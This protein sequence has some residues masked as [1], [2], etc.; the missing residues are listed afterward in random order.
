MKHAVH[1]LKLELQMP[2]TVKLVLQVIHLEKE[3]ELIVILIMMII[4]DIIKMKKLILG[5]NVMKIV[6]HA[7]NQEVMMQIIAIHV[8][9]DIISFIIKLDN[10]FLIQKNQMIAILKMIHI[11]NALKDVVHV[12]KVEI[13][14]LIIVLLVLK[15]I[16]LFIINQVNVF[17]TAKK[18]LI[19]I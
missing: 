4:M 15:V 10:V 11:K 13:P 19:N 12:L 9:M 3:K 14:Q 8:L 18:I 5:K 6:K 2:I 16:T 1:V 7:L 17:L